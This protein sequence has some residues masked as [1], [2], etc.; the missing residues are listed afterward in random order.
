ME[1]CTSND[2]CGRLNH[3]DIEKGFCTHDDI[4]PLTT[5]QVIGFILMVI[6]LGI[7]NVGGL[8]I[9]YYQI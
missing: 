5:L 8:V 6:F 3:C 2:D 9:K 1:K 4:F 7:S